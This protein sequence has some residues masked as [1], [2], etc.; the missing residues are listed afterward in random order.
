[1]VSPASSTIADGSVP[2]SSPSQ[3]APV[4]VHPAGTSSL[5]EYVP[6]SSAAASLLWPPARSMGVPVQLALNVKTVGSSA[7]LVTFRTVMVPVVGPTSSSAL[8]NVQNTVSPTSRTIDAGSSPSSSPS[9]VA[10]VCNQ[11][12]GT[13]S[14][15]A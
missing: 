15:I 14:L 2:S 4:C 12:A 3:V 13:T 6:G 1:M 11:P 9:Q 5:T 10:P 8:L 7:G